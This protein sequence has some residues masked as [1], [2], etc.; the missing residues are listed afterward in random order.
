MF[1]LRREGPLIFPTLVLPNDV[2][3]RCDAPADGSDA[4]DSGAVFSQ[5][6]TY[7]YLLWRV[8]D[9][10]TYPTVFIMLN[11]STATEQKLDPTVRRCVYFA[12]KWGCGGLIVANAFA[13]RATDPKVLRLMHEPVGPHNDQYLTMLAE[14][15]PIIV[16]A[17]GVHC[18]IRGRA[19]VVRDLVSAHTKLHCLGLTKDGDPCH[20]LYLRNDLKPFVYAKRRATTGV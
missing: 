2:V 20:P 15:F 4:F 18:R 12:K 19:Q 5:C 9:M 8:W 14:N 17:W 10:S 13:L 1:K 3:F 16:A 7:R 6:R 11:P